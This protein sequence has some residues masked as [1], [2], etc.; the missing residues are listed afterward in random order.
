MCAWNVCICSEDTGDGTVE[1]GGAFMHTNRNKM[2]GKCQQ[3][4]PKNPQA[5]FWLELRLGVGRLCEHG[6]SPVL[7]YEPSLFP[8]N[9]E[10]ATCAPLKLH[11][12][13]PIV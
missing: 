11:A 3:Y 2:G 12:G 1:V 10:R 4:Q 7:P 9:L 8:P 6:V 5:E 13:A